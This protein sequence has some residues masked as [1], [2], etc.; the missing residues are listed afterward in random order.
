MLLNYA[1]RLSITY[2]KIAKSTRYAI[3]ELLKIK[4]K[5]LIGHSFEVLR[6]QNYLEIAS[7]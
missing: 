2:S 6:S 1:S 3:I 4:S 5:E 7:W